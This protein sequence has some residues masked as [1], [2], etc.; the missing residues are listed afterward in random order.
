[1]CLEMSSKWLEVR[2]RFS[3]RV[4]LTQLQSHEKLYVCQ[5]KAQDT[6]MIAGNFHLN[7]GRTDTL[8]PGRQAGNY[9]ANATAGPV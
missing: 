9:V 2:S 8:V 3:T 7:G 1:M 6:S 5:A 4:T